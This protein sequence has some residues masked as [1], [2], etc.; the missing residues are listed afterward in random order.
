MIFLFLRIFLAP[1]LVA[2]MASAVDAQPLNVLFISSD[3]LRPQLGCYGD[4]VVKSPHIDKRPSE[5]R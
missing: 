3:D 5:R 1:L 4:K 2:G